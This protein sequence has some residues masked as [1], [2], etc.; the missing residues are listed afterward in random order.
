M[1]KMLLSWIR[2]RHLVGLYFVNFI[3]QSILRITSRRVRLIHFTNVISA[4]VGFKLVGEGDFAEKCLRVNGGI[5][6]QAG[7]GVRLDRSVLI[8]PGV[9][10][11]SGNHDIEDFS[12]PSV[13]A[14]SIEIGEKC[15]IGANSV[16]LPE[17]K[18]LAGTI[19]GAG[20][21][22]TRSFGEPYIVLAGNPACIVRRRSR[23]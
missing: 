7:N 21:V 6:I 23:P 20:S 9:K 15:W 2:A 22:V 5:L 14:A 1:K 18:L 10:I 13:V 3:F 8:G 19:V 11:I 12:K 17:V 4:D 16:I